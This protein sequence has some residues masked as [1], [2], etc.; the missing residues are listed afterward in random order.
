MRI[1][2]MDQQH[3]HV[4]HGQKTCADLL[5]QLRIGPDSMFAHQAVTLVFRYSLSGGFL[6]T[7]AE[8]FLA[9]RSLGQLEQWCGS[10]P[11]SP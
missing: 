3:G 1:L 11:S 4:A 8:I 5:C 2:P 10:G 9:H 7:L 6:L